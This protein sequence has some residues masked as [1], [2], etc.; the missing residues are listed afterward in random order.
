[1]SDLRPALVGNYELLL[2][3][4]CRDAGVRILRLADPAGIEPHVHRR[5]RQIYVALEG[6]S[7]I[8]IDGVETE[9]TPYTALEVGAEHMHSARAAARASII[10][11]ISVPPLSPDDQLPLE[12]PSPY[13]EDLRLPGSTSD[14]DD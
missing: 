13:R 8:D 14:L 9:L 6:T 4:E 3:F 11:N 7:I 2:D 5:T 10:M 12:A 1:M